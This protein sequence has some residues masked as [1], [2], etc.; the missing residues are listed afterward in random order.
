MA[1]KDV[2][3]DRPLTHDEF[4]SLQNHERF[5]AVYTDDSPG[6][7]ALIFVRG[8]TE[9]MVHRTPEV[10]WHVC[11]IRDRETGEMRHPPNAHSK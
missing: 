2:L 5:D 8:D 3:P 7:N 1:L 4:Q 6:Y 9:H 10:G 11:A